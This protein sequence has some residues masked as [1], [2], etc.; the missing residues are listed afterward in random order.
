MN[1]KQIY[2]SSTLL[3]INDDKLQVHNVVIQVH[4]LL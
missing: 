2:Y 3:N 4:V 1:F